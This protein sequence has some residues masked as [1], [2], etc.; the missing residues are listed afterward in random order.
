MKK[1][2]V[3]F[4]LI[5]CGE[6]ETPRQKAESAVKKYIRQNA[7]APSSYKPM[8]F[9]TLDSVYT[10][11]GTN[12][13]E[14]DV[15]RRS[16]VA[17][18]NEARKKG[19]T[20]RVDSLRGE[21]LKINNQMDSGKIF[22]GLKIY[23]VSQGKNELGEMVMNRGSFYLDSNFVVKEFIMTEDSLLMEGQ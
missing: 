17:Q 4:L 20:A 9:G 19:L 14:L 18:Y 10:I 6:D 7:N 23:H 13:W 15:I 21:L 8:S 11:E 2:L 3:L 1:L 5:G 12:Y 16:I 22:T